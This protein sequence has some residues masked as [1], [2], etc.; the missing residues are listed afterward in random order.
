MPF[1]EKSV[2]ARFVCAVDRVHVV[3]TGLH[4][5]RHVTAFRRVPQR[6]ADVVTVHARHDYVENDAI[7]GMRAKLA[8]RGGAVGRGGHLESRHIES[9][10]HQQTGA[11]I[12]VDDQYGDVQGGGGFLDVHRI[13]SNVV[14]TRALGRV[15]R[16]L[17][18]QCGA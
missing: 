8:Q 16:A 1:E 18:H 11:R 9:G 14:A 6:T 12:V 17:A 10:S 4:Q 15:R 13:L 5:H 2:A 3:E 7:D